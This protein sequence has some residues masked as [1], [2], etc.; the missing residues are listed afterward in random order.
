MTEPYETS[1]ASARMTWQ[2]PTLV[3]M[4]AADA[5]GNTMMSMLPDATRPN[6]MMGS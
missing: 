6:R 1:A 4:G 2:R 5:E 3:R